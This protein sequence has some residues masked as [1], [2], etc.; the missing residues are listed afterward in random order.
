[1]PKVQEQYEVSKQ[2]HLSYWK[3]EKVRLLW[4]QY[5]CEQVNCKED[6]KINSALIFYIENNY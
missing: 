6:L 5:F 1:M 3:E 4:F 2:R